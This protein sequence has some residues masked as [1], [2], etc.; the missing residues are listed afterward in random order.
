MLCD[1]KPRHVDAHKLFPKHG[2][3]VIAFRTTGKVID[4]INN[5]RFTINQGLFINT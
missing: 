1:S 3:K 4:I 5:P 2:R